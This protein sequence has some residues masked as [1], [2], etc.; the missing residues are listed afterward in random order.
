MPALEDFSVM[1]RRAKLLKPRSSGAADIC[2]FSISPSVSVSRT[3]H[4]FLSLFHGLLFCLPGSL[5]LIC[6]SSHSSTSSSIPSSHHHPLSVFHLCFP[7]L[8]LLQC[9]TSRTLQAQSSYPERICIIFSLEIICSHLPLLLPLCDDYRL[10]NSFVSFEKKIGHLSKRGEEKTILV[11]EEAP[12]SYNRGDINNLLSGS[13]I[14][15]GESLYF[16]HSSSGCFSVLGR[17]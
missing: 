16:W 9:K 1:G 15:G 5:S 7:L 17:L 12:V 10:L 11:S 14:D 4:S 13:E 8:I 3:E 2:L 6:T